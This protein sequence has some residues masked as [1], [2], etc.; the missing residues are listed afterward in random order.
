MTCV[1]VHIPKNNPNL[2]FLEL[3][4]PLFELLHTLKLAS[5]SI[6]RSLVKASKGYQSSR[7]SILKR[8][9]EEGVEV[10]QSAQFRGKRSRGW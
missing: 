3:N 1:D 2:H 9:T 7:V 4:I 8:K 5:N 10:V 6:H